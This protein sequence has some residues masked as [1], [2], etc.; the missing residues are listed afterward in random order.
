[1][2]L[3]AAHGG[4]VVST[5][6]TVTLSHNNQATTSLR[7]LATGTLH[8]LRFREQP[9]TLIPGWVS[10]GRDETSG[11]QFPPHLSSVKLP[12]AQSS[13]KGCSPSERDRNLALARGF[14]AHCTRTVRGL[15]GRRGEIKTEGGRT[16]VEERLS[17]RQIARQE[18]GMEGGGVKQRWRR[19]ER[20][21]GRV[22]AGTCR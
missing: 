18:R 15:W 6:V 4:L 17:E 13:F 11:N 5:A 20:P 12:V 7:A 22:S 9:V 8:S 21:R 16:R 1:M 10:K 3:K 19:R 14:D 2:W